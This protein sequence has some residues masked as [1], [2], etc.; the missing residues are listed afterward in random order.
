MT[1][2][3]HTHVNTCTGHLEAEYAKMPLHGGRT[4]K[5]RNRKVEVEARIEVRMTNYVCSMICIRRT[6]LSLPSACCVQHNLPS[7]CCVQHEMHQSYMPFVH[8]RLLLAA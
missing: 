2:I 1:H 8:I 6:C 4:A 7:A 3:K 5:E